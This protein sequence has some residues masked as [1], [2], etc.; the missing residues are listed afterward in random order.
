MEETCLMYN[1]IFINMTCTCTFVYVTTIQH[2]TTKYF[3]ISTFSKRS[4]QKF[5][6]ILFSTRL[7]SGLP[8]HSHILETCLLTD[9][10]FGIFEFMSCCFAL[11]TFQSLQYR[12]LFLNHPITERMHN[13]GSKPAA[14][15]KLHISINYTYH[16]IICSDASMVA[17][18][19]SDNLI[20]LNFIYDS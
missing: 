16:F 10:L 6:W 18:C 13:A 7:V 1:Y 20:R 4:Q 9:R 11:L 12:S 2:T 8:T 19:I 3:I 14:L 15:K 5:L 17:K